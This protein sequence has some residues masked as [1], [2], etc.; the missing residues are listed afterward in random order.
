M[1][2]NKTSKLEALKDVA[3]KK[4]KGMPSY[5]VRVTHKISIRIVGFIEKIDISPDL[6]TFVSIVMGF[7]AAAMFTIPGNFV[8]LV[9]ALLLEFY[10]ILDAVDGQYART[11]GKTSLTGGYFDYLSNHIVHSIVFL[12]IGTGLFRLT[13]DIIYLIAGIF[14]GGG[15]LFTYLIHD[16]KHSILYKNI[17]KTGELPGV[18]Q[19]GGTVQVGGSILKRIFVFLHKVCIYPTAM[20]I[21]TVVALVSFILSLVQQGDSFFIFKFLIIFY[22][23]V[24]NVVWIA[25]LAKTVLAKELDSE[26][27]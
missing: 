6:I 8:Y 24:L 18:S 2:N 1:E 16:A 5:A 17:V 20:N 4:K 14:A 26:S 15:M 9:A 19:G 22:S 23:I 12:G 3:Y 25:K 27:K 11:K 7:F 10:Y 21:I 13:G